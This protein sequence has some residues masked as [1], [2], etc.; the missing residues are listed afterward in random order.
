MSPYFLIVVSSILAGFAYPAT[1]AALRGFAEKDL[2]LLRMVV[3][4]IPFLP[5]L[6][7]ARKRLGAWSRGDW[8]RIAAVG[9]LGYAL[10]LALGTYG[11]KLSSA[12]SASLL[13]GL[14]PMTIVLL[15]VLFLG[16]R[17]TRLKALSTIL[18][19][20]GATLIAF[21]GPPSFAGA[22]TD[23][24][25]GDLILAGHGACWALYS[26]IG[27]SA[28]R[29]VRPLD[30]TAATTAFGLLG[31]AAWAGPSVVPSAW[32]GASSGA[33]AALLYLALAG[34]FLAT[35]MWNAA[36]EKVEAG[37]AANFIFLQPLVGVL[38]GIYLQGD[39][40]TGWSAAGGA[41]VLGGMWAATRS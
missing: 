34:G 25:R 21:Q 5:F 32:Q 12:T 20:S 13:V 6:W 10:P 35:W 22:F 26:V 23:R 8:A 1:T 38:S 40:F 36:L 41:L 28:L 31:I 11:L 7:S 3:C 16:E 19:L 18:G 33:W 2:L 39:P 14:E 9:L 24:L 4:M 15:S 30:F 29:R 17:M 37:K 27:K